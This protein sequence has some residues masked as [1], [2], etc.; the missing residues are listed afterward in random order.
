MDPKV[1]F[2]TFQPYI[3]HAEARNKNFNRLNL[4]CNFNFKRQ[5]KRLN[6]DFRRTINM[7]RIM[8]N[9]FLRGTI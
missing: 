2:A 7:Q 6:C 9:A 5:L 8:L 3:Q 4:N 1:L